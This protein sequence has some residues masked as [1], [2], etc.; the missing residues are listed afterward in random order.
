MKRRKSSFE[1]RGGR[2]TGIGKLASQGKKPKSIFAKEGGASYSRNRVGGPP[3]VSDH[4][5]R[6]G[7]GEMKKKRK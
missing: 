6:E 2:K 3:L 4:N 5:F 1:G 7:E